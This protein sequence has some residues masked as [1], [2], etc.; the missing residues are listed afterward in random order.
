MGGRPVQHG[1]PGLAEQGAE[2]VRAGEVVAFGRVVQ[3]GHGGQEDEQA[4][5]AAGADHPAQFA[6]HGQLGGRP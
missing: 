2:L 5:A 6:E 3:L 4:D 1:Q